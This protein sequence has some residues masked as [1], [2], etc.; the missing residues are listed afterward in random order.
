MI[1]Q[2][3]WYTTLLSADTTPQPPLREKVEF[4]VAVVG[5]GMAGLHAALELAKAKKS[6]VLLERNVCGGSTTGKSAG[7]LTPDSELDLGKMVRR[8]GLKDAKLVWKMAEDGV[9]LIVKSIKE[10]NIDCDL[11]EQDSLYLGLGKSGKKVVLEEAMARRAMGFDYK[12]HDS[13]KELRSVNT[14]RGYVAGLQYGGTFGINPLLYA[15]GLKA[16]LLKM[17]VKIYEST[18]V[19][20]IEKNVARTHLGSV[21]AKNFI[22]CIDKMKKSFSPLADKLYHAQ[23]FLSVSEPLEEEDVAAV[24]PGKE[25]MCWD[26]KLVYTY[27]RLTGDRR[28]LLGGGSALSTFAP[29]DIT[30]PKI[31]QHVI[32]EFKKHFP[33]FKHVDFIQYWPGRIDTTKDIMPIV[34][35]LP[36]AKHVQYVLGCVGLPWAAWC[37]SYAARR[38]IDKSLCYPYCRFLSVDRSFFLPGWFQ[39]IFGKMLAFSLGAAHAKYL[40]KE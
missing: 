26:T 4:E 7:F 38:L 21:R 18:E 31:I 13:R 39:K 23:T 8:Y 24:F 30:S 20:S 37:G 9:A 33:R 25:V 3:W 2:N 10:F 27:Y 16:Q 1:L 28:I 5:G 19:L 17:G 14:G 40:K 35:T 22:V 36:D 34:D 12:L 29:V 15:Q 6:V 32:K 11:I